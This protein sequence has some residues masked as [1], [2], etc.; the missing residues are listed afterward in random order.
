MTMRQRLRPYWIAF[1]EARSDI[2]AAMQCHPLVGAVV[3]VIIVVS[4]GLT[5]AYAVIGNPPT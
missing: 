4:F 1:K 5:V 2:H 3:F